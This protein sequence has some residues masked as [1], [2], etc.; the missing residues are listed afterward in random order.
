MPP[1]PPAPPTPSVSFVAPS[2]I[3]EEQWSLTTVRSLETIFAQA[4]EV[5]PSLHV[6]TPGGL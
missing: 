1:P 2:R 5:P 4:F 6:D 3:S